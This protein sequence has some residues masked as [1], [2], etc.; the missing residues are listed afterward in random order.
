MVSTR[1]KKQQNKK[2]FIE[3][4][5]KVFDFL[6]GRSNQDEQI[7]SRG[8][9]LYRGTSSDNANHPV[10]INYRQVDVHSFEEYFISKVRSEVYNLMTS[11][12]TRV[13]DAVLTAIECLVIPRVELAMKSANAHSE[14]SVD[15]NILELDQRDFSGNIKGLRITYSSRINSHTDLYRIDETRGKNTVEEG[16]LLVKEKNIDWQT[17]AHHMVTGQNAP[18][19]TAEFLSRHVPAHHEPTQ[20]QNMI[21]QMLPDITLP[22]LENTHK[23]ASNDHNTSIT[24]LA[25]A[26]AG[27]AS[28]QPPTISAILKPASA[29]TLTFE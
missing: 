27:I 4:S 20:P 16:N 13:L 11:V 25:E 18:K 23:R 8:Y 10:Q 6:I 26:I 24:R 14:W 5:E 9:I 15:G 19:E 7:E 29:N 12:K 22:I 1:K 2:F 17:Y 3:L 21:I 28:Q